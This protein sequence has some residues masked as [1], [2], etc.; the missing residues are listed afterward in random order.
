VPHR[1]ARYGAGR[2][3]DY[4]HTTPDELAQAIS[5]EIGRAVSYRP[6]ET[7][8]AGRAAAYLAEMF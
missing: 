3:L 6:V 4:E 2:R 1:L 7:D 5:E 8:G